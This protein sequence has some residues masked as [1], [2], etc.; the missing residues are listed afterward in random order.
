VA[1]SDWRVPVCADYHR[2]A[3]DQKGI[4]WTRSV[5]TLSDKCSVL[6]H[7]I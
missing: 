3:L 2:G 4:G 5:Y 1:I 7:W 6:G